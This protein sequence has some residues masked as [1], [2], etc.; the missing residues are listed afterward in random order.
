M[1]FKILKSRILVPIL[2]VSAFI[3]GDALAMVC[4]PTDGSECPN[5]CSSLATISGDHVNCPFVSGACNEASQVCTKRTAVVGSS[6]VKF[7]NCSNLAVRCCTA[8]EHWINIDGI[9]Y[10]V[11]VS[12][13]TV[14][15][16]PTP[17]PTCA[18][19]LGDMNCGCQ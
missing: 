17:T 13:D 11:S 3:A 15:P 7:C 5:A 18:L 19:S 10:F 4:F 1:R 14:D 6:A 2:I 12:C 8:Y 16:C 9:W